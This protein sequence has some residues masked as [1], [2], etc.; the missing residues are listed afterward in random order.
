VNRKKERRMRKRHKFLA[1]SPP[2]TPFVPARIPGLEETRAFLN[3]RYQVVVT[4]LKPNEPGHPVL[5]HLSIKRRDKEPVHDWRDLQRIKN[6][7]AGPEYEGIEIYPAE[8]RL[9]D[10]AN[11]YHLWVFMDPTFRMSVGFHE[12]LVAEGPYTD[13]AKQ[14]PFEPNRRPA[15]CLAG[16]EIEARQRKLNKN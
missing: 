12:R 3:S 14:R 1:S 7:L 6:E 5:R 9:V 15:D 16:S 8:E 10:T 4:D 13:G 2:W 11:Q